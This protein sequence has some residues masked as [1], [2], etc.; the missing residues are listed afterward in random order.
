ML[1]P[2]RRDAGSPQRSSGSGRMAADLDRDL[3]DGHCIVDVPLAQPLSV[4]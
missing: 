2:A 4:P 3:L 1:M